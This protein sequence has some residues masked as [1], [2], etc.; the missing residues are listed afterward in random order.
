MGGECVDADGPDP[1]DKPGEN[2]PQACP[3]LVRIDMNRMVTTAQPPPQ[4]RDEV[5]TTMMQ[6]QP[7]IR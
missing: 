5:N 1:G 7:W 6:P 2:L 4:A 3:M